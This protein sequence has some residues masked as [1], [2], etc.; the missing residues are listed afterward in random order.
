MYEIIDVSNRKGNS[1][2]N[3]TGRSFGR[4]KVLGLSPKRSGRKSY[5]VCECVC[6]NKKVV[7][8]D[9]LKDGKVKSCGCLKKEQDEI[10]LDRTTHAKSKTP[11]HSKWLKIKER[12][13]NPNAKAFEFYGKRGIAMCEEWKNNFESFEKWALDNGYSSGL[14]IERLDNNKG[15]NPDN[16]K[17]IPFEEQANNRRSTIWVEWNGKTQNLT[18]WADELGINRGTLSSRYNR[19]NLR[20]PELFKPVKK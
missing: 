15:Y 16:C 12:C 1:F 19:E 2:D 13:Y 5:W 11:L 17:W 9:S 4:L 3:L 7:R 14:T 8:S 10:N 20:P 6:G 18:Q